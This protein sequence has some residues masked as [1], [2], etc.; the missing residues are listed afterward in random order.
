MLLKLLTV[1]LALLLAAESLYILSHRHPINRFKPVDGYDG[2]VAFDTATGQLCKTLRT[3]SAAEIEQLEGEAANEVAPC[4][5]L[6]APSGD[7]VR[8][9][10]DRGSISK[11]CGGTGEDEDVAQKSDADS[12]LEFAAK[13]PACADIR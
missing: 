2:L 8:D 10:L 12:T 3:K 9:A 13:L 6:P 7:K 4:P 5:P 1:G 11:R